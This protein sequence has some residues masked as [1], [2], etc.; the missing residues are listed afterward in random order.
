MI[1]TTESLVHGL[2]VDRPDAARVRVTGND[3]TNFLHRMITADVAS[4]P[5]DRG[6]PS[7]LLERSGRIVDRVI[8]VN[9]GEDHLLLGNPGRG[10]AVSAWLEKYV[11]ADDVQVTDLAADTILSTVVGERASESL[12][13]ELGVPAEDLAPWAAFDVERDG[14]RITVVRA[15]D[16]GARSFH[17][18]APLAGRPV[19]TRAL[20]HLPE[21]EEDDYRAICLAAGL[22]RFGTEYTDRTIPLETGMLEE[23]SF[24]KGCFLGQEVIARLHHQNRVRRRLVRLRVTGEPPPAN[25][26][27]VAGEEEAGRITDAI[28][29]EDAARAFAYVDAAMDLEGVPLAVRD[30]G[31]EWPAEM[32]EGGTH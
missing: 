30:G 19:L 5:R 8:V 6:A 31:R 1:R 11:I 24:T 23:I 3:A 4:L 27:L 22:P 7:F 16:V 10:T 15:D 28:P 12:R 2:R 18:V 21:G 32:L 17:L 26:I 20:R 13:S 25:A 29:W 14:A 9:R